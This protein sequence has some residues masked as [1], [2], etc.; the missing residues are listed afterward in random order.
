MSFIFD[1]AL[2]RL[3]KGD[4]DYNTGVL[5]IQDAM[6]QNRMYMVLVKSTPSKTINR[7]NGLSEVTGKPTVVLSGGT[8]ITISGGFGF[9]FDDPTFT[10]LV[11]PTVENVVGAV[12]G[13]RIGAVIDRSIDYP[14][15]YSAFSQSYQT[16]TSGNPTLALTI[17]A[18]GLFSAKS[19]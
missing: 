4:L 13:V 11:T 19:L 2:E 3:A 14:I 1:F 9:D 18:D 5:S 12:V 17:P 15:L 7:M 10:S 8:V 6:Y 16:R